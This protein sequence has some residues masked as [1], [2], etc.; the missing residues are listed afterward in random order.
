MDP[1]ISFHLWSIWIGFWDQL[2]GQ[3]NGSSFSFSTGLNNK[4]AYK[5]AGIFLSHFLL[6]PAIYKRFYW[7]GRLEKD[8]RPVATLHP[9]LNKNQH[10]RG[11][12]V[13]FLSMHQAH[14][15]IG[16]WR[17]DGEKWSVAVAH[18]LPDP[19]D[20]NNG[21]G[22]PPCFF[23]FINGP[24]FPYCFIEGE[25]KDKCAPHAVTT[26]SKNSNDSTATQSFPFIYTP[27]ISLLFFTNVWKN[28]G[29]WAQHMEEVNLTTKKPSFLSFLSLLCGQCWHFHAVRSSTSIMPCNLQSHNMKRRKPSD[30]KLQG[31]WSRKWMSSLAITVPFP[32]TNWP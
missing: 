9:S 1:H 32:N 6:W 7:V 27:S 30:C 22:G 13:S 26:H 8:Q 18:I 23:M 5:L 16:F 3:L 4:I 21:N 28:D 31:L 12:P 17:R 11:P 25:G 10:K 19:I 2:S 20:K 15:C 29:V 14:V 24:P